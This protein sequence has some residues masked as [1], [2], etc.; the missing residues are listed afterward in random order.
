MTDQDLY[1][2]SM[3]NAY[4]RKFPNAEG[5]F[6]FCDRNNETIYKDKEL[7]DSLKR[8]IS[9]L[10]LLELSNEEFK[11]CKEHIK[12]IPSNYWEWLKQFRYDTSKINISVDSYLLDISIICTKKCLSIS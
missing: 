11:W 7:F 12:Y 4:M 5:T 2:F 1:K 6:E 10:G 9:T 3:S 8:A